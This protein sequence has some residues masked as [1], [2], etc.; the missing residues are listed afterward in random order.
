VRNVGGVEAS[1]ALSSRKKLRIS[2]PAPSNSISERAISEITSTR[3]IW[4]RPELAKSC[5]FFQDVGEIGLAE[6]QGGRMPNNTPVRAHA[7]KENA[8]TVPSR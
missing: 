1:R 3:R 4:L 5:R 7:A 6:L 8:S 2:S